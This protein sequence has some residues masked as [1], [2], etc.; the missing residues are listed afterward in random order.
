MIREEA[1]K[2]LGLSED[3]A[4]NIKKS[5]LRLSRENHPDA[6]GDPEL[7]KK[8]NEAYVALT[9]VEQPEATRQEAL[10]L[11]VQISLEEAIF[12]VVLETHVRPTTISSR[13]MIGDGKS[14]A[15][16]QIITVVEKIPPMMLLTCDSMTFSHKD[17]M[18]NGSPRTINLIYS[19][20][21]HERYKPHPDKSKAVLEVEETIPVTTALYGGMIEVET[22]YGIRKLFIKPG[23]DI[24]D[25]YEIKNHGHLG[26]LMVRISSMSMPVIH[27]MDSSSNV[28]AEKAEIEIR[29]EEEEIAKNKKISSSSL[30]T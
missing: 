2:I 29:K 9:E 23:T 25:I 10:Y 17:Q 26:S 15:S 11:N 16:A 6:G 1:L 22:L 3:M 12:G 20:R 7:F 19:I 13:P 30:P 5:Y 4:E 14:S 27:D 8:I 18:L 28:M 24:G 21:P